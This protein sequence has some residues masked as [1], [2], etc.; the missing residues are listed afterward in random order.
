MI[1]LKAQKLQNILFKGEKKKLGRKGDPDAAPGVKFLMHT[2]T[3]AHC[4]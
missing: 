3:D 1:F 4:N 2:V